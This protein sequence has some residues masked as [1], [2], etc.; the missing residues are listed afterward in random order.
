MNDFVTLLSSVGD[1]ISD[2]KTEIISLVTL[3]VA[4]LTLRSQKH[5]ERN[6]MPIIN[7]SVQE[8]L[9]EDLIIRLLDAQIRIA[10]GWNVCAKKKYD[11]YFSER[12][13]NV[14]RIPLELIHVEL[15]YNDRDNYRTV[16]GLYDSVREYNEHIDVLEEHMKN[17]DI[18]KNL[19]HKEFNLL[20]KKND[21]IAQIWGKAMTFIYKYNDEKLSNKFVEI[22]KGIEIEVGEDFVKSKYYSDDDVYI[23]FL[24]GDE[25]RRKMSAFM[26]NETE[27]LISV[28]ENNL[29]SR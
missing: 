2:N 6:T 3:V 8:L 18:D 12:Y 19:I 27:K 9:F 13:L 16:K 29:I 22:T 17:K 7:E 24:K 10:A 4:L 11:F 5:T 25:L 15:F 28:F 23:N 26:D 21:N 20:T 14:I 1:Y